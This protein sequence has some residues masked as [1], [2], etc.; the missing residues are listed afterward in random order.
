MATTIVDAWAQHPTPRLLN[1]PMLE[2]LRRWTRGLGGPALDGE[3]Q[4]PVETTLAAMDAGGI[5]LS[6]LSAWVGPRGDL[7]SNDEVAAFVRQ[8]PQ[9]IGGLAL[10]GTQA[11]PDTEAMRRLRLEASVQFA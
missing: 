11:A 10:L 1:H 3:S 2:S 8:A 9:R 5:S 6:L 7:I 4:W